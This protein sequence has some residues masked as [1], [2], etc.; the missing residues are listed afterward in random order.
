MVHGGG[1]SSIVGSTIGGRGQRPVG[2]FPFQNR[3]DERSRRP[4]REVPKSLAWNVH[5]TL[6]G[7]F[8]AYGQE[9]TH[10]IRDA[11]RVARFTFPDDQ[12][13]P[14]H[15]PKSRKVLAVTPHVLV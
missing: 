1:S 13:G 11:T 15:A 9:P 3:Q 10:A 14:A 4:W 6:Q 2:S 7:S 8:A 12:N 5:A